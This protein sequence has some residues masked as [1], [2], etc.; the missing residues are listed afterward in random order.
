MASKIKFK[1]GDR[2]TLKTNPTN[3]VYEIVW[4]KDNDATCA[5]SSNNMRKIEKVKN[6]TLANEEVSDNYSSSYGG[7]EDDSYDEY[8]GEDK[9]SDDDYNDDDYDY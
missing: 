5:I 4:Y 9:S 7:E 6:L 2:V 8:N 1:L 3:Q